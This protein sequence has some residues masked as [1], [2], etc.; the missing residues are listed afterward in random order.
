MKIDSARG[1]LARQFRRV[2]LPDSLDHVLAALRVRE[3]R[4]PLDIRPTRRERP[5]S[6]DPVVLCRPARHGAIERYVLPAKLG[7]A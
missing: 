1:V 4:L 7:E 6:R 2:Q 3:T 5:V